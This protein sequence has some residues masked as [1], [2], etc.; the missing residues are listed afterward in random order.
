MSNAL[1]RQLFVSG[2]LQIRSFCILPKR[3]RTPRMKNAANRPPNRSKHPSACE[4]DMNRFLCVL[5]LLLSNQAVAAD[6]PEGWQTDWEKAARQAKTNDKPIF[7][8]F[9][10]P[11]C[12]P[13]RAMVQRVFPEDAVR[14]EMQHWIPVYI[15]VDAK[16]N[17]AIAAKYRVRQLPTMVY[18]EPDGKEIARTIGGVSTAEK[19]VGLLKQQGDRRGAVRP[20]EAAAQD[21]EARRIALRW[22]SHIDAAIAR[23]DYKTAAVSMQTYLDRYPTGEHVDKYQL[24]LPQ[25]QDFLKL[26]QGVSFK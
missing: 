8:L 23:A 14:R 3:R 16:E 12:G 6:L 1:A 21:P 7:I 2:Y 26:S 4:F 10:A 11:W 22:A 24:L 9:S 5:A 20:G 13:C 15:D 17:K 25:I 19:M 18:L